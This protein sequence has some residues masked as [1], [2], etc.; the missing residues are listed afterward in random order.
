[1]A[2]RTSF[3]CLSHAHR[4]YYLLALFSQSPGSTAVQ[5]QPT[6]SDQPTGQDTIMSEN[7]A[8]KQPIQEATSASSQQAQQDTSHATHEHKGHASHPHEDRG[9][10]YPLINLNENLEGQ[11]R[12]TYHEMLDFIEKEEPEEA[13]KVAHILLSWGNVPVLYRAYA[14]MVSAP[15]LT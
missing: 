10:A 2:A 8:G 4:F 1:M 14:H 12:R 11:F 15:T 7:K 13:E 5:S 6:M 3:C 9:P